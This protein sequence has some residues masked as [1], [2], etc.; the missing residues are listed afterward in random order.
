MADEHSQ[1]KSVPLDMQHFNMEP[2][3]HSGS[4][5]TTEPNDPETACANKDT[6]RSSPL[7]PSTS[8]GDVSTPI[9]KDTIR[10]GSLQ[11]ALPSVD[12]PVSTVERTTSDG[13]FRKPPQ[14]ILN[15]DV[16]NL[17]IDIDIDIDSHQFKPQPQIILDSD[18]SCH[19][20]GG[21]FRTQSQRQSM[22]KME[23]SSI[24]D[25]TQANSNNSLDNNKKKPLIIVRPLLQRERMDDNRTPNYKVSKTLRNRKSTTQSANN[26]QIQTGDTSGNA[27]R[28]SGYGQ[29][30]PGNNTKSSQSAGN[31]PR[32]TSTSS[33][34]R[35]HSVDLSLDLE[36]PLSP[37]LLPKG[38]LRS[39]GRQKAVQQLLTR[40]ISELHNDTLHLPDV[41]P[42]LSNDYGGSG[43]RARMQRDYARRQAS[44]PSGVSDWDGQDP[45]PNA[46]RNSRRV[47]KRS[48]RARG[49]LSNRVSAAASELMVLSNGC[50]QRTVEISDED[51]QEQTNAHTPRAVRES[52]RTPRSIQTGANTPRSV[53]VNS[54]TPRA[55]Q[56]SSSNT[57]REVQ[58]SRLSSHSASTD[59]PVKRVRYKAKYVVAKTSPQIQQ[60]R[61]DPDTDAGDKFMECDTFD[62][63]QTKPLHI[64][65]HSQ[66]VTAP[67]QSQGG[68]AGTNSRASSG[69]APRSITLHWRRPDAPGT[70]PSPPAALVIHEPWIQ[71]SFDLLAIQDLLQ[72]QSLR[73]EERYTQISVE[74]HKKFLIDR[75]KAMNDKYPI[76]GHLAHVRERKIPDAVFTPVRQFSVPQICER[77]LSRQGIKRSVPQPEEEKG[78][79]KGTRPKTT[80]GLVKRR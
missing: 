62:Q 44:C 6:I 34:Q 19:A 52:V 41:T 23:K 79:K 15:D 73:Q 11:A 70:P 28:S 10:G 80:I 31:T 68:G 22:T 66:T 63:Q 25:S 50:I 24:K 21:G 56:A 43:Y 75:E 74:R 8:N 53:Q 7:Q 61:G 64:S 77:Y 37:V 1:E 2:M 51:T 33:H 29:R 38:V 27:V 30:L 26:T 14:I 18:V 5:L 39:R 32:Y 72:Q 4:V 20:T 55:M 48:S 59:T 3:A 16:S 45:Q 76:T 58:S 42:S 13:Q 12:V 49:R 47:T 36:V 60:T 78:H 67:N 35:K 65:G 40:S 17:D 54:N 69:H 46:E 57:L 71:Q 9:V